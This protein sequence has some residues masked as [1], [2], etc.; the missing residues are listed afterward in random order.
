MFYLKTESGEKLEI[1]DENTYTICP[2]CGIEHSVCL[3]DVVDTSGELDLFGTGVYC[4]ECSKRTP[5]GP[6]FQPKFEILK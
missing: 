5:P 4:V 1:T 6:E 3:G 2:G